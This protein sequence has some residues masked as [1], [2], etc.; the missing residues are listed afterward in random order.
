MR[1]S[2][3][4]ETYLMQKRTEGLLFNHG[5][6][7][8]LSFRR[9]VGNVQLSQVT[10]RDVLRFLDERITSTATWRGKYQ[11][12]AQFFAFWTCRRMTSEFVM[13]PPRPAVR[14]T[15]V[16]YIFSRAELRALLRATAQTQKPKNL[17]DAHTFRAFLLL[18]Y[19][20]GSTVG[21][22]LGLRCSDIDV[23]RRTV[24]IRSR[25]P[26][27]TRKLPLGHDLHEAVRKYIR[28]RSRSG[29]ASEYF[30]TTRNGGALLISTVNH[31]FRKV[32]QAAGVIRLDSIAQQP[33]MQDL[34]VTFAVHRITSWIR[35]GANLNRMLP[36]LAVYMGQVGLGATEKYLLMTP[37]HYRKQLDVLSPKRGS[38]RWRD[39][40]KLMA[41]LNA[42]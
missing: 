31:N 6:E 7:C 20:T 12:L 2:E 33:R 34:R 21:E 27:Q 42:L 29:L 40:K 5:E 9:Q 4:I 16:P 18:M 35:N 38:T 14:Q 30:F 36:A 25:N 10:A 26:S 28:I 23:R 8:F 39:D 13:P 32:R 24:S 17:I 37:E 19:G 22:M 15:F 11:L 1:L 41:F 3:G